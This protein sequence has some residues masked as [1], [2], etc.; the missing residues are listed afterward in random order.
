MPE[1]TISLWRSYYTEAGRT[2]CPVTFDYC[3]G[4]REPG[5]PLGSTVAI[6]E[7]DRTTRSSGLGVVAAP[8]RNRLLR[9]AEGPRRAAASR[10]RLQAEELV[11]RR[12]VVKMEEIAVLQQLHR[13]HQQGSGLVEEP[14]LCVAGRAAV[15][16]PAN[17]PN[18]FGLVVQAFPPAA[19]A[20]RS[21]PLT[22]KLGVGFQP[23]SPQSKSGQSRAWACPQPRLARPPAMCQKP[24]G[25]ACAAAARRRQAGR[26]PA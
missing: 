4:H 10:A 17:R 1:E 25:P 20:P 14:K 22:A 26:R 5:R 3:H 13:P 7:G 2:R 19:D 11:G 6:V 21:G 23:A 8:K 18:R 12:V 24:V 15:V 16:G 9:H